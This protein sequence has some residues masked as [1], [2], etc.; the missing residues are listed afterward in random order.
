VIIFLADNGAEGLDAETTGAQMLAG[1]LKNADNSFANRGTAS[2]YLTYGAGWAQAATAPSWLTKGY[3]SEG[4]TRAVAF[5]SGAGIAARPG[6]ETQYLSVADIAPTLLDLAGADAKATRLRGATFGRSP[7][8]R[9]RRGSKMRVRAF[10]GR[11]TA[12]APNFSAR[13]PIA[14]ATG[15][16]PIS[17]TASGGCST[18]RAIPARRATCRW[19]IPIRRPSSRRHGIVMRKMSAWS[20][21]DAVPYRP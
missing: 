1:A 13:A 15:K 8:G 17:A 3:N 18:L 21:P 10:M 4:G 14:A 5:I 7:A 11:T 16:S 2:S 12:S 6:A 20:L 9:G 19:R